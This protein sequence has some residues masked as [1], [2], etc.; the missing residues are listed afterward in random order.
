MI[1]T[2]NVQLS[3]SFDQVA[4]DLVQVQFC[5]GSL[6][7]IRPGFSVNSPRF[8]GEFAQH[9]KLVKY[10]KI[11]YVNVYIFSLFLYAYFIFTG[12]D[13]HVNKETSN[14]CFSLV[15]SESVVIN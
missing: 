9:H 2:T 14:F 5:P 3:N 4:G 6:R 1:K 12:T 8:F 15:D 10:V 11:V 13:N 7:W